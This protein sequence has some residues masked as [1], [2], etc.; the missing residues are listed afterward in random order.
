MSL[1][2]LSKSPRRILTVV[3]MALAAVALAGCQTTTTT[4]TTTTTV[5]VPP[6]P[7]GSDAPTSPPTTVCESQAGLAGPSTPPSG[8]VTLTPGGNVP[9]TVSSDPAGTTFWFSAGTYTLGTTAF[10]QIDPLAGDSFVGGPGAIIDGDG[11]NDTAFGGS[12]PNVTIE[13]LTIEDFVA[14]QSEGVVN[15]NSGTGW[16]IEHDTIENNPH[17]AGVMLGSKDVLSGDCLTNNGQYGFQTYSTTG[18][19]Q[20]VTITGNEISFNDTANYTQ[21]TIGCG[22]SG[23]GKFWDT[24]GATIT[25]NYVHNNQSVGLW[26]DTDNSGFDVSGNYISTNYGE[27]I[28]YEISYNADITDNTFVRNAIGEGPTNPDFPT[29]AIYVSESGSDSRVAGP[30]D[31]SFQISY[32]VFLDNW[33]GV[34]LWEN[35]NRYCGSTANTSTGDC[36]LITPSIYTTST[37]AS[38][39]P[40]SKPTQTPDYYDN[41]RWKTQNVSVNHNEFDL[42][43]SAVAADCTAANGCGYNALFSEYGTYPPYT[44]WVVPNHIANSQNNHFADNTYEGP[45]QFMS[46]NQG[47]TVTWA[48]WTGGFTDVDG[49]N[50]HVTGQDAGSS[51]SA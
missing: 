17:G 11:V 42:T 27:G 9:A 41:C 38:N 49:S 24:T 12:A 29:G 44:G 30:Y 18:S 37:C 20:S 14:P 50:D 23:G 25:G 28:I 40:T 33:S 8:A 16:E 15:H 7:S 21:T 3:V 10:S 13:Y 46:F 22:C 43:S 48:Q 2:P 4:T 39:V 1:K 32:N 26:M 45:W 19:P 34:V 51:L 6:P 47:E 36:T 31:T 35:A 5:A